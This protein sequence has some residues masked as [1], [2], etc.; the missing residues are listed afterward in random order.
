VEEVKVNGRLTLGENIADL[1]GVKI[2][3]LAFQRSL[4]AKQRP[5]NRDGFTPEQRF[6][7]AFSQSWRSKLR[8]EILR[9]WS[10]TDPHSPPRWRVLGVLANT[11]AFDEA[12]GDGSASGKSYITIW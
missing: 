9:L 4:K 11:P 7:L 3:Y 8:P 2:A 5:P 12:F 1:G 6:F 10:Q